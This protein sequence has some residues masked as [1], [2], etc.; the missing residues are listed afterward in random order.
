MTVNVSKAS[1]IIPYNPHII[2]FC[3]DYI[4]TDEGGPDVDLVTIIII[5][6]TICKYIQLLL[7]V[8]IKKSHSFTNNL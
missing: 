4:V 2:L 6:C 7:L 5:V 8:L 3:Q 1:V